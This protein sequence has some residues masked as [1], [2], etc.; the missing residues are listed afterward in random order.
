MC[1]HYKLNQNKT[2][3]S[4]GDARAPSKIWQTSAATIS[5]LITPSCRFHSVFSSTSATAL[6]HPRS[7]TC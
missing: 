1:V 4:A 6:Q 5:S 7:T 3:L 2:T